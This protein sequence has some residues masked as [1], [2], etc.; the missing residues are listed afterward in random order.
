MKNGWEYGARFGM[1]VQARR[2]GLYWSSNG[3]RKWKWQR[4]VER[5][6][7]PKFSFIRKFIHGF[8]AHSCVS[9][10]KCETCDAV[11]ID[12]QSEKHGWKYEG[13]HIWSCPDCKETE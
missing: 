13:Y 12:F 7:I 9:V 3:L 4:D 11:G 8:K 10:V 1:F 5:I 2:A 6:C